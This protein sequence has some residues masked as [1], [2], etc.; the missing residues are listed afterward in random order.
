MGKIISL[1][2]ENKAVE[3]EMEVAPVL[4]TAMLNILDE[5]KIEPSEALPIIARATASIVKVMV[6]DENKEEIKKA[7]LKYVECCIDTKSII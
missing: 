1:K 3:K 4:S 5:M 7:F 2:A 6:T